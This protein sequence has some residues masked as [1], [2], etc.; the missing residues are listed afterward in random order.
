MLSLLE[1]RRG[2]ECR[3]YGLSMRIGVDVGVDV[4]SPEAYCREG[5][6]ERV[7]CARG[8]VWQGSGGG[9]ELAHSEESDHTIASSTARAARRGSR[10]RPRGDHE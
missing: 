4:A 9:P 6:G 10:F 8:R 3:V 7:V 5:R 2:A 1:H